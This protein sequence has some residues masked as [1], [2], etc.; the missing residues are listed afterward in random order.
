MVREL[1]PAKSKWCVVVAGDHAPEWVA[2]GAL[3]LR[4]APVQY[5]CLGGSSTL[6]HDALHRA[7][8]IAPVSQILVTAL[9]EY[10]N[11]WEPILWCVRPEVRFVGDKRTNSVLTTAAAILSIARVSASSIVTILPARCYVGHEWILHEALKQVASELPHVSEGV[12]T[13]GMIDIDE[14][15][16]EDY[17]MVGRAHG[18]CGFEVRGIARRPTAWVARHLRRQGAVVSSGIMIG[19]AGVFAA[20]MAKHWPEM[21]QRL[22]NLLAVSSAAQLECGIPSS[23]QDRMP[24]SILKSPWNPRTFPQRVFPVCDSGWSGLESPH[25]VARVADF[26]AHRIH[27]HQSL[28]S[29]PTTRNQSEPM[30]L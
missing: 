7:A 19:Y 1:D 14:G 10:R 23:L 3:E 24:G 5:G 25:A 11:R 13:L 9:E 26:L 4:S 2:Y 21:T 30:A 28:S 18:G 6:L 16:D 29:H 20:H 27:R 12:A 22:T 15:A 17:M 8:S